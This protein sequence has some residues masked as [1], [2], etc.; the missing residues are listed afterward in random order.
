MADHGVPGNIVI[1]LRQSDLHGR[2]SSAAFIS[3][4]NADFDI[5][6][7]SV[8][9][10]QT[11]SLLD[12]ATAEA[13][14]EETRTHRH[15]AMSTQRAQD[16]SLR[17][18]LDTVQMYYKTKGVVI[19]DDELK[20]AAFPPPD[21]G[22]RPWK[23]I[24]FLCKTFFSVVINS[25]FRPLRKTNSG[26]AFGT[27]YAVFTHLRWWVNREYQLRDLEPPPSSVFTREMLAHIRAESE[28]VSPE[29]AVKFL[30][31]K[32]ESKVCRH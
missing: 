16:R 3:D 28:Q 30:F 1:G 4:V 8:H 5:E 22:S 13:R 12:S 27:L 2:I 10:E 6:G 32:K 26:I 9:V 29:H 23:K 20:L 25:P 17:M 19:N 14:N 24:F 11:R 18:Y 7:F 31:G 21:D 15:N